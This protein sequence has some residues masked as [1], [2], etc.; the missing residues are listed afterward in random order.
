MTQQGFDADQVSRAFLD[1]LAIVANAGVE[2]ASGIPMFTTQGLALN[3]M[4]ALVQAEELMAERGRSTCDADL[5]AVAAL[6]ATAGPIRDALRDGWGVDPAEACRSLLSMLESPAE[7]VPFHSDGS[8]NRAGFSVAAIG[9][10]ELCRKEA[11]GLGYDKISSYVFLL[12]AVGH[13]GGAL[14]RALAVQL[15]SP[16][17]VHES[18][19]R[20]AR[21][22]R[23]NEL[24][25]IS[26][27]RNALHLSVLKTIEHAAELAAGER[28]P[29]IA[30]AH[31]IRSFL[32]HGD[33]GAVRLLLGK[34]VDAEALEAFLKTDEDLAT[35]ED[36]STPMDV[37]AVAAQMRQRVVGQDA[38][39]DAIVP[40]LDQLRFG[41]KRSRGPLRVFFFLGSSGV[42]KTELG[43]QLAEA[44][45]GS[46]EELLM[47]E[48]GQFTHSTDK[49][50]LIGAAPGYTGYGEGQL[51]NGLRDKPR[52]VVLFDEIE[53]A[54]NCPAVFDVILRF[55]DE[56]LIR[57]PAG[58]VRDGRQ[59]IVIF[60]S[61]HGAEEL[62][63]LAERQSADEYQLRRKI[64]HCLTTTDSGQRLF[65]EEFINRIDEFL[66]FRDLGRE[67]V[68]AI[69]RQQLQR[70]AL[71]M[72][73]DHGLNVTIDADSVLEP[74]AEVCDERTEEGARVCSRVI[75][76]HVVSPIIRF[77]AKHPGVAPRVTADDGG[78]RVVTSAS[79]ES[80]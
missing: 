24:S 2:S 68:K 3:A 47:L 78:I 42:G 59:C 1:G 65:R 40:L 17:Q 46:S 23:R 9:C 35:A 28:A 5:L 60:T 16:V 61:N 79:H 27:G 71:Q 62:T 22:S 64:R 21:A 36:E 53:K 74:L 77:V 67:H 75:E 20:A 10:L 58:P 26:L 48:M 63:K 4:A 57:D 6:Q 8:L 51:T 72:K 19:M 66:V 54:A 32:I 76:D 49:S 37:D 14:E 73:N 29:Q 11:E 43:K 30:E 38:V 34:A 12:G 52:C 69:L 31:L 13:S 80:L 55:L 7:I 25:N 50:M 41:W 56:G 45:Y 18:A 70:V 44:V 33:P 39:I 15:Q